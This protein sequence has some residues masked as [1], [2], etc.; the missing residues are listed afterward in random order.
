MGKPKRLYGNIIDPDLC[1]VSDLLE[2]AK[3]LGF[4]TK[5][6]QTFDLPGNPNIE[7][8]DPIVIK[9]NYNGLQNPGI[10]DDFYKEVVTTVTDYPYRTF[11]ERANTAYNIAYHRILIESTPNPEIQ[12]NWFESVFFAIE[13]TP[14]KTFLGDMP[15]LTLSRL[16]QD[17]IEHDGAAEDLR[18]DCRDNLE[19]AIAYVLKNG[20]PDRLVGAVWT[21]IVA[22]VME[23][24]VNQMRMAINGTHNFDTLPCVPIQVL[25]TA[26]T[27][28]STTVV[29]KLDLR[30]LRQCV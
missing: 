22:Y 27:E 18:K 1:R 20:G 10:F 16:I 29:T 23:L 5:M 3:T 11:I 7:V 12:P 30:I 8:F 6:N 9:R 14:A 17:G 24:V 13:W 15:S 2:A 26:N 4:E 21:Y 19:A 28:I 25:G